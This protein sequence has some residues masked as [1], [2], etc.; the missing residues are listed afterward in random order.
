MKTYRIP[1]AATIIGH[2]TVKA[3]NVSH[4]FEVAEDAVDQLP[5]LPEGWSHIED[6]TY[7]QM[8]Y[9]DLDEAEEGL[10]V[11]EVEA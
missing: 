3:W 10:V 5:Q 4:A 11:K 8:D 1:L 9:F 6:T 2:V 7:A